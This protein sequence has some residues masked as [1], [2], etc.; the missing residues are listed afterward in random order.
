MFNGDADHSRSYGP[1]RGDEVT[2]TFDQLSNIRA[3]SPSAIADA[4]ASRKRRPLLGEDG[5]LFII[6]A[7]HPA[8]GAI[9][10]GSNPYA[11]ESRRELL[12]RLE[13]ALSRPGVDGVLATPD[14]IDD[15]ALMGLLDNKV[16]VGSLNRGGL[17]G[18]VFEFDDRYTAYS[19]ESIASQGLDFAKNLIRINLE[20][21]DSVRTLEYSA[22]AID[23]A[24][25]HKLPIMLEPFMSS[26]SEGRVVNDLSPEAVALAIA[27]AQGLG[28]S[29]AYS[30][31]KIPVVVHME[32]VMEAS[33]LP[34]L[35][36]GGETNG[37]QDQAYARW[38][39]ALA[40]PGVRGLV[41]GR[42]LL[43]PA[44]G[45]VVKAVD[46]AAQLVH[47]SGKN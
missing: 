6:A 20:D 19:V 2:L 26:W 35:L 36:L 47:P 43:Y 18:S 13:A 11:M 4:L 25:R 40:L 31:L 42:S 21:K 8:R 39:S 22:R 24:A 10:V 12:S 45:D 38:E 5:R 41:V 14:V 34:T 29:S 28:N 32:R 37:H 33:T 3:E 15:L 30:W 46:T 17:R 27:I 16:V 7:D 9:G 23:E 44:D 1:N